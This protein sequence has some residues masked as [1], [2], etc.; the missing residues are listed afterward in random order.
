M[1]I[2][3]LG[4]IELIGKGYPFLNNL[5]GEYNGY[6][7]KFTSVE[8]DVSFQPIL[9]NESFQVNE[10]SFA[11]YTV[12]RE[13]GIKR[14]IALPIFLNR[15]FRHG[16]LFVLEDSNLIH[17]SQLKGKIIGA[18]EYSQTAAVWWRGIM[19]DE[20]NLNWRDIN[21]VSGP[22]RRF[23]APDEANVKTSDQPVEEL[24]V[25]GQIDAYLAPNLDQIKI[26][27]NRKKLRP[28]LLNVEEEERVY[29]SKTGI[30]PV[31]HTI[32]IHQDCLIANPLLP[33]TIFQAF[34]ETKRKYYQKGGNTSP[35]GD[36]HNDDPI[37]FG[38]TKINLK[39]IQTL[40]RY[41]HEQKFISFL[42]DLETMFVE[43]AS[44]YIDPERI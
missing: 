30:Y 33:R 3:D 29:F 27:K 12:M 6:K 11:N 2:H 34:S 20:F 13:K 26:T 22:N 17:P 35:W 19:N 37:Q 9:K 16:S 36:N 39:N 40:W 15:E 42:P 38:L 10:F 5:G 23:K 24:I 41:L 14:M 32:V 7:L 44:N 21:W 1:K 31:N 43:G 25:D 8:P 18:R 28:L 4:T